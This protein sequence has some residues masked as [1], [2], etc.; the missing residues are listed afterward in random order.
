MP[1]KLFWPFIVLS[2]SFKNLFFL[3]LFTF[4]PKIGFLENALGILSI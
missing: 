1:K 3:I 2:F 4:R